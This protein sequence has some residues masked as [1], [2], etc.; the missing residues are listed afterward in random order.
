MSHLQNFNTSYDLFQANLPFPFSSL[1]RVKY[2]WSLLKSIVWFLGSWRF[3]TAIPCKCRSRLCVKIPKSALKMTAK[4][5]MLFKRKIKKNP[6][7]FLTSEISSWAGGYALDTSDHPLKLGFFYSDSSMNLWR[8]VFKK[9]YRNNLK[10]NLK[11][12]HQGTFLITVTY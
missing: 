2:T 3:L 9:I 10:L 4:V 1:W 7:S 8:K 11:I 6:I 5:F 12:C